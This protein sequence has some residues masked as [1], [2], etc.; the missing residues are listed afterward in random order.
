L[1]GQEYGAKKSVSKDRSKGRYISSM[2]DWT[3]SDSKKVAKDIGFGN[4]E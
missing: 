2:V 3:Q 1:F 4:R